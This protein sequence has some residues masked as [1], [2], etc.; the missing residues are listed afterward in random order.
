[1][2]QLSSRVH[3][4]IRTSLFVVA[5]MAPAVM[6][7][8]TLP[9]AKDLIAKYVAATGAESWK[10]HKSSRMKA[11]MDMPAAGISANMEILHI[12]PNII[13]TKVDIPG[14]G[15]MTSG[16][17]GTSAWSVN[18][19]TGPRV[20][21]GAELEAMRQEADPAASYTRTSPDIASSETVEKTTMGGQ[22]CYKVKH[23]WKSGRVSYDCFSVADGLLVATQT[24]QQSP[25]GEIEVVA[26]L[27]G[28]K[29]FGGMKRPTSMTQE[30]MGQQQVITISSWEWDNV[31][32]KEMEIPEQIKAML[33]K[34]P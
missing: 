3:R 7:G 30:M 5:A 9:A 17:D 14:M 26:T 33:A 1:M 2:Q 25:M 21:E 6:R 27:S 22:E 15:S 34:K 23:T 28:Y 4:A 20:A 31:D 24:K 32:A 8:Q 19:M 16:F 18:P 11:T 10:A 29:D 12:Y 13:F